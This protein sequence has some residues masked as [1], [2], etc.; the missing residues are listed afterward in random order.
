MSKMVVMA[1][2]DDVPHLSDDAKREML[3]GTPPYL[4]DSRSKGIP[5]MG[6]GA[7]YP[8]PE[9]EIKCDVIEVPPWYRRSYAL[10]VGWN[11]TAAI[12]GAYDPENDIAYVVDAYKR[13]KAEPEI[14]ASAIRKR[15]PYGFVTPGVVDPAAR[16]R[17]Q[18][19]GR[20]L[21]E[22]YRAEGLKLI[23]ADNAVEAGID[24]VWGRLS[25][26]RL[27]VVRHL[28]DFFDE[29]RL[30]RRD[31]NGRVVKENDHLMDALRYYV[32]TGIKVAKPLRVKQV[33][34]GGGRKYF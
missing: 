17:S 21:L 28:S 7:I 5:G 4:R 15:Y 26:G 16:S 14:H 12:F 6:S 23:P 33:H 27:K 10:D 19:D 2:W 24:A 31:E 29:Y 18:T 32:T 9:E 20:Q 8:I 30:Y 25:T 13:E 34:G 22:L 3:A 11:F 1:G